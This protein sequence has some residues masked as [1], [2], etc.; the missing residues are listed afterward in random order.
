MTTVLFFVEPMIER[1]NPDLK[2]VWADRW[3]RDWVETLQRSTHGPY[4]IGLVINRPLQRRMQPLPGVELFVME[5]RELLAA[6]AADPLSALLAWFRG[7]ASHEQLDAT[8]RLFLGRLGSFTPD[9]I[10]TWTP[11]PYL[12]RA[13]ASALILHHEFGMFSRFPFPRTWYLDPTGPLGS[14][15]LD[16]HHDA[17]IRSLPFGPAEQSQLNAF[18]E[19]CRDIVRRRSP[20]GGIVQ[21]FRDRFARL[22]LLPLQMS[23]FYHFDGLCPYRSQF[24]YLTDVLERVPRD[25]GV[26]VTTHPHDPFLD[27]ERRAYIADCYPHALVHEEFAAYD[28]P[29]E[30][31]A[32]FVDGV[33]VVSSKVGFLPLLWDAR[34]ISLG[35]GFLTSLRDADS[36]DGLNDLLAAPPRRRDAELF[37]LLTRY[38]IPADYLHSPDWLG[39]FLARGLERFRAGFDPADFFEPIAAPSE[40]LDACGRALR[41]E[42]PERG[43]A[44]QSAL[45]RYRLTLAETRAER[46]EQAAAAPV[47]RVHALEADV[48]MLDAEIRRRDER[49]REL[50]HALGEQDKNTHV[51]AERARLVTDELNRLNAEHVAE[52]QAAADLR[53]QLARLSTS[54]TT[55][56]AEYA[57]LRRRAGADA[58]DRDELARALDVAHAERD[59]YQR[60]RSRRLAELSAA[61]ESEARLRSELAA[62]QRALDDVHTRLGAACDEVARTRRDASEQQKRLA[63]LRSSL[64]WRVAERLR[65]L[66]PENRLRGRLARRLARWCAGL[67]TGASS[68]SA[69]TPVDPGIQESGH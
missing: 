59:E 32:P 25:V 30:Y 51:Y 50:E 52:K 43:F 33:V 26:L 41:D 55:L 4:R 69:P 63:V 3:V 40:L 28:A 62:L 23:G 49:L 15:H 58:T 67:P 2:L 60:E 44:D 6:A 46:A 24:E 31:L 54:L 66:L 18:K 20:F 11:V 65:R 9:I 34:L 16:R 37:W 22:V 5:Q 48:R 8:A 53:E 21:P 56:T 29:S 39:A 14:A 13:F 68:P 7:T 47:D 61:R 45:L 38:S 35:R 17:I 12:R 57:E 1:D 19:R 64:A 42:A 27:A 10:I 36:L